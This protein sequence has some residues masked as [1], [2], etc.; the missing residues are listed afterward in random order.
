MTE[1]SITRV[2]QRPRAALS[3]PPAVMR[4]P[5]ASGEFYAAWPQHATA[6]ELQAM[7]GMFSAVIDGW[8][9]AATA[10]AEQQSAADIEYQSWFSTRG[11]HE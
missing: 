1:F 5:L 11:A 2:L 10:R 9:I 7:K 6:H 8:I 3:E 4:T